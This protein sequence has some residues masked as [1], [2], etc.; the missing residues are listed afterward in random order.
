MNNAEPTELDVQ[1]RRSKAE[2]RNRGTEEHSGISNLEAWMGNEPTNQ[3]RRTGG[4][5]DLEAR[6]GGY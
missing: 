3:D 1:N 4:K 2:K 6:L 5:S